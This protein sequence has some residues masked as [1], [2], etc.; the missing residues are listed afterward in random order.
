MIS[1]GF[2]RFSAAGPSIPFNVYYYLSEKADEIRWYNTTYVMFATT[3]LLLPMSKLGMCSRT[4]PLA[5]SVEIAVEILEAMDES[6]VARKS[7]DIIMHYLRE[8]RASNNN[9]ESNEG[10]TQTAITPTQSDGNPSSTFGGAETVGP[11]PGQP[12]FDIPV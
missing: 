5:R 8:F 9:K 6:V 2:I 3:T 11:G 10:A 4:I 1:T 7:V 12:G